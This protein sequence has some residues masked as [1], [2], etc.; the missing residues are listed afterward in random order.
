MTQR[1]REAYRGMLLNK[2]AELE[3]RPLDRQEIA[4]ERS[5]DQADEVRHAMDREWVIRGLDVNANTLR[6]V[7]AALLRL[8][9]GGFGACVDCGE[10]I[11]PKRL[12]A[13]PWASCCVECQEAADREERN[14]QSL[15]VSVAA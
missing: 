2:Q 8:E 3:R 14:L 6:L 7:R 15:P 11:N 1:D 5:A 13:L 12:A 4:V 10:D 9:D